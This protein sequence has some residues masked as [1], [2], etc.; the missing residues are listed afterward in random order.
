[1][2][3]LDRYWTEISNNPYFLPEFKLINKEKSFLKS[4]GY[5]FGVAFL[6]K[7][8]KSE[9]RL[10]H[11]PYLNLKISNASF[12]SCLGVFDAFTLK[13]ADTI[14]NQL[15]PEILHV[16][17]ES[18]RTVTW[19]M[20][21]EVLQNLNF[22]K[23]LQSIYVPD[24]GYVQRSEMIFQGDSNV[25]KLLNMKVMS[26]VYPRLR[27]LLVE[28]FGANLTFTMRNI[29]TA[30]EIISQRSYA[31]EFIERLSGKEWINLITRLY[32]C[33]LFFIE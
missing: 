18:A 14:A 12:L 3:Y 23:V 24:I 27:S 8:F 13:C 15:Y 11:L 6:E 21:Y 10:H 26:L 9:F 7:P 2:A 29:S 5:E 20:F 33:K 1:L 31:N 25:A 4:A 30:L 28:Q 19:R 32:E 22:G 16:V 17:N